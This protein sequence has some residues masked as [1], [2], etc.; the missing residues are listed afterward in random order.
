MPEALANRVAALVPIGGAK[1]FF[2]SGGGESIDTAA[3]LARAYWA[4]G[5]KPD[6]HVVVSRQF[7]YHGS[8]AY[9]T[10]LGGMASLVEGYGRLVPEVEQGPGDGGGALAGANARGGGDRGAAVFGDARICAG[11]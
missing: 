9:G 4:A 7:A 5:G 2:P 1:I 3:K 6:K 8:N 10:S 11:G